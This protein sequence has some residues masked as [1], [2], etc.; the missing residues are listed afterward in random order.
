M[1]DFKRYIFL[2]SLLLIVYLVA[3][4][5]RPK[6]I[7]WTETYHN[8]DKIPFG[9]YVLYNRLQDLFPKTSLNK[10][11]LPLTISLDSTSSKKVDYL[12][13]C[14]AINLDKYDFEKLK[15]HLNKGNDVFI[16]ASY[17]GSFLNS[18]LK[19]KTQ[20]EF[21][22]NDDSTTVR[23]VNNKID[24]QSYYI[25]R[26]CTQGYFSNFDTTKAVVLGENIEHHANFLK[27][28]MGKGSLYLS[29][30]PLLFTNYSILKE[31][32]A[33]YVA[34]SLSYLNK[35]HEIIWDE[36]FSK[37]PQEHQSTMQVFLTYKQL[38]WTF[39]IG[40]FSLLFYVLYQMKR[41]QRIIP[42]IDPVINSSVQ[43]ATLVGQV[44]YEKHD[45]NNI[46]QKKINYFLESI[47]QKYHLQ[48]NIHSS[49]FMEILCKKSGVQIQLIQTIFHQISISKAIHF[50]DEELIKLNS[51]IQQFYKEAI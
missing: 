24:G 11:T 21:S 51:N 8:D 1:K 33:M 16:A 42:I 43:F 19:I 44:Y 9:T 31:P 27:F 2:A 28:K 32:G 23:F 36:Y 45:N 6:P 3:Q 10:N 17:F 46:A 15:L 35:D 13:I 7:D 39:Y 14:N 18:E 49:E 25:D 4:Y 34:T 48:T 41:R 37:G 38:K 5:N 47:R 30:N 22:T 26:N 40:F 50:T 12:I 20:S 29:V